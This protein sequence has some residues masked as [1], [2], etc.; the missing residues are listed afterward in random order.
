[1]AEGTFI[2]IDKAPKVM[3]G[4]GIVTRPL[5]VRQNTPD[6]KFTTGMTRFPPGE[7]APMH[8]HNC[9]EQVTVL[10]GTGIYEVDGVVTEL[11]QHDT[12]Y[13]PAGRPHR[14][15]N[16]GDKAMAILWIYAASEVTRTFTETGETVAHLSGADLMVSD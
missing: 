12:T 14:F 9:D 2:D 3:R 11:K 13:I 5:I 7:G 15:H 1:M 8:T 16:T 4:G 6:A 10:E